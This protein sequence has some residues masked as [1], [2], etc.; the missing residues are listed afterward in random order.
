MPSQISEAL[1]KM[2]TSGVPQKHDSST[3]AL[4]ERREGLP[5]LLPPGV[6]VSANQDEELDHETFLMQID[7]ETKKCTFYSSTGG[8]WTLVTHGGIQAIATQM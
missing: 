1:D 4:Q 8:Y 2:L 6:N 3:L 5:H 7:Q